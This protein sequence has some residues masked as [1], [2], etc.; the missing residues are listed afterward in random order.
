M[1]ARRYVPD[2]CGVLTERNV[3]RRP[4]VRLGYVSLQLAEDVLEDAVATASLCRLC[5]RRY[6]EDDPV[7]TC[8]LG[9]LY[10]R[11]LMCVLSRVCMIPIQRG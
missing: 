10:R 6:A 11:L 9:G 3:S 5:I 2:P 8:A 4:I 7:D 1:F